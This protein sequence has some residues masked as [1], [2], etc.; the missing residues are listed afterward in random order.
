MQL[1]FLNVKKKLKKGILDTY[2]KFRNKNNSYV[3]AC[4]PEVVVGQQNIS[5]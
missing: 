5:A 3:V 1:F 4:E 2:L